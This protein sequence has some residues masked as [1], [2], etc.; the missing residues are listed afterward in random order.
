M[1]CCSSGSISQYLPS[2]RMLSM[3]YFTYSQ[4]YGTL[5]TWQ[6]PTGSVRL[7]SIGLA[8]SASARALEMSPSWAMR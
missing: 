8:A 5:L 6:P 1:F 4:K 2:D 3:S 7:S